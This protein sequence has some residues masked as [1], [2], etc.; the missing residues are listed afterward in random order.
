MESDTKTTLPATARFRIDGYSNEELISRYKELY[1]SAYHSCNDCH[2]P[3]NTMMDIAE[4]EYIRNVFEIRNLRCPMVVNVETRQV[5]DWDDDWETEESKDDSQNKPVRFQI[6]VVRT[7]SKSQVFEI[8]A[9]QNT[10]TQFLE[11]RA[12]ELAADFD[13]N[14]AADYGVP[15]YEV[16]DIVIKSLQ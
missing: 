14:K 8:P 6:R 7:V 3:R 11:E 1:H 2:D 10:S 9:T 13:F 4:L 12:L 15:E 16:E 5:L